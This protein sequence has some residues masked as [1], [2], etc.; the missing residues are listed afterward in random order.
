VRNMELKWVFGNGP[1][2]TQELADV[3]ERE[4][5]LTRSYYVDGRGNRC[6]WGV[7]NDWYRTSIGDTG[8]RR[9][10]DRE[11]VLRLYQC[12]LDPVSS[13]AFGGTLGERCVE[14]ARRLRAIL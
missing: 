7:I 9:Q 14:M 3:V 13:D 8:P 11:D 5:R 10:L 2:S 6:L 1:G 4:G 12:H